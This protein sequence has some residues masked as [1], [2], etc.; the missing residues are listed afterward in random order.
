MSSRPYR[1]VLEEAQKMAQMG[2]KEVILTGVLIGAYGPETG[3]GGPCFEDLVE[4][5]S[6]ELGPDVRIRISSIEMRQV[7]PRL[8]ELIQACKVVPHLHIPLQAGD[9]GVLKDMNRP[10]TQDDY[11]RLCEALYS[12]VP[13]ISITTDIMVGFP[14]ETEER[15]HS[16]VH[17]CE[18]ARYL[19][20]HLFR[21]SPR[22][23]TP[24]DEWGDPIDPQEKQ[25][26]SLALNAITTRTGNA[27]VR[28][29]LGRTMR[30]LVEGKIGKD[31]L[32]Q[33]LTDNYLE[34]KFAG[35]PSMTRQFAWVRLDEERDGVAYGKLSTSPRPS[36][37]RV[38]G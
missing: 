3:S 22:F 8:I 25:R 34:V 4:R 28:R 33:G 15:F 36:V 21:F 32:L 30:V 27:H 6:D 14:T 20:A 7:T 12:Q 2:Y 24:A 11:L 23:G 29:F 17:V 31:G 35:S 18:T 5:L 13:D 10:Y 37:L 9:T 1:E 16:T 19:K 26:R 38:L